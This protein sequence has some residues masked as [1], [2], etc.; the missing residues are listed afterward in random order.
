MLLCCLKRRVDKFLGTAH[1]DV[2]V[3]AHGALRVLARGTAVLVATFGW[4][5]CTLAAGAV[6]AFAGMTIGI[7]PYWPVL[8]LALPLTFVLRAC[9]CLPRRGAG[10]AAALAILLAGGYAECLTA[11]TRIAAAT[12]YPFW[13][14]FR[15]GGAGLVLLVARLGLNAL[16]VLVYAAAA[17]AAAALA[18]RLLRRSA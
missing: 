7:R 4:L 8:A 11:I 2:D 3:P 15:T 13:Q 10:A 18:A 6:A 17:A 12:G 5:M 16:A 14:A 9:G 1:V